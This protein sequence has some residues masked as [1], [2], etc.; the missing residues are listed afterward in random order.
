MECCSL[1][2][3]AR[4][5]RATRLDQP[6]SQA[7]HRIDR[8][9]ESITFLSKPYIY[10]ISGRTHRYIHYADGGEELYEI[11]VDPYEWKN[12]AASPESQCVLAEFRKDAPSE[13]AVRIEPSVESLAR[14]TW[15]P[16][17]NA[18]GP[19]SKPDGNS[20]PVHFINKQRQSVE[21]YWI[22]SH[23]EQKSYGTIKPG[24]TKTQSTRPG[25]VWAIA[26]PNKQQRL[27]YFVVGDRT[28]QAV[29]PATQPN[30]I[31]ILTDDQGW[32]DLGCQGQLS[33]IKT[34]H[35]DAMAINNL[36][37]TKQWR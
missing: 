17:T 19:S 4:L 30:V 33:D 20:F 29:I 27:G 37:R 32:S 8:K 22:N 7:E 21:L 10:A 26:E 9:H 24:Q 34:P 6:S 11:G 31:V 3:T 25:A 16:A 23:G 36:N 14:L 1:T 18:T 28:A 2:H 15:H 12:L 5:Q 35:I 13:F